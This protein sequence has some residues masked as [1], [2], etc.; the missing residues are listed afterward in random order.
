MRKDAVKKSQSG[1]KVSAEHKKS[2]FAK[3]GNFLYPVPA[4]MVSCCDKKGRPNI[5]TVAWTG[6]VCS[7]P[8]MLSISVRKERFSHHM[9]EETGEFVV[10]LTSRRLVKAADFC[11]V[12]SG[13]DL[14]KFKECGLTPGKSTKISAPT[15]E[16]A[17]VSIEC[18]VTQKLELGSHDLFLA[19]VVAV[20]AD[21]AYMDDKGRFHLE[22]ADLTCYSHGSYYSL[23]NLIGTFGYSVRKRAQTAKKPAGSRKTENRADIRKPKKVKK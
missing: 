18:R 6:T 10:N 7:D 21:Q 9:I 2:A 8:P 20:Q 1:Q 5:I 13:R 14:D 22:D 4:A 17:P 3:P 16:E 11:G 12:R 23:G 19:E 15:I